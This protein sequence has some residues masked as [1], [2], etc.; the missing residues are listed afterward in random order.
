MVCCIN[1]GTASPQSQ[2]SE[3][4]RGAEI[5][6]HCYVYQPIA[7]INAESIQQLSALLHGRSCFVSGVSAVGLTRCFWRGEAGAGDAC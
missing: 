2:R 4:K 5:K 3:T 1:G 6:N 7:Q